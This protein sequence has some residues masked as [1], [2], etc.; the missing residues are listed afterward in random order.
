[1][2]PSFKGTKSARGMGQTLSPPPASQTSSI[3]VDCRCSHCPWASTVWTWN[4]DSVWLSKGRL[5]QV[6]TITAPQDRCTQPACSRPSC[7]HW[8]RAEVYLWGFPAA[9]VLLL[10][11][12]SL[13][14]SIG[15][16]RITKGIKTTLF[17]KHCDDFPDI[18]GD[19]EHEWRQVGGPGL[20]SCRQQF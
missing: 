17:F 10:R 20:S 6:C 13:G 5:G 4:K 9:S 14:H 8:E 3:S 7:N 19:C 18:T 12:R 11:R 1:M 16:K 2:G 15:F